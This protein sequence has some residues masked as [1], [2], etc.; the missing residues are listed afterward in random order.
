MAVAST[1]YILF[2]EWDNVVNVLSSVSDVVAGVVVVT[3]VH[4]VFHYGPQ[5]LSL[6]TTLQYSF[7]AVEKMLAPEEA[8]EANLRCLNK[9]RSFCKW[10]L[11]LYAPLCASGMGINVAN[12]VLG[13]EERQL[14]I[15]APAFVTRTDWIYWPLFS[16]TCVM[17]TTFVFMSGGFDTLFLSL[18]MHMRCKCE[19]LQ[20]LF[21]HAC[22]RDAGPGA[23]RRREYW[24]DDGSDFAPP[25]AAA[26]ARSAAEVEAALR[27]CAHYHQLIVRLR[28]TTEQVYA[29]VSLVLMAYLLLGLA[30][31]ALRVLYDRSMDSTAIVF[32]MLYTLWNFSQL[33]FYC[34]F[35]DTVADAVSRTPPSLRS[36]P[37][38]VTTSFPLLR[39]QSEEVS[40]A[41]YSALRPDA[42]AATLS[43]VTSRAAATLNLVTLRAQRPLHLSAGH[44][45]N[46]TL[47]LYLDVSVC[48][49]RKGLSFIS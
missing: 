20:R 39:P 44:F 12:M 2:G 13:R 31:P 36:R 18:C 3:K 9:A 48:V 45:V 17:F 38:D 21:R 37:H 1:S 49:W 46:L 34:W 15:K 27:A 35:A 19:I 33:L 43:G 29:H 10:M 32:L 24:A 14:N 7:T 42:P 26:A 23:V 41:A 4:S 5:L 8:R 22:Q 47:V 16:C 40:V 11:L 30:V 25:P 6:R 28:D